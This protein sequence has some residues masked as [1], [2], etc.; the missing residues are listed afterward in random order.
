MSQDIEQEKINLNDKTENDND[1]DWLEYSM[2][3]E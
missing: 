2:E 3:E 1:L